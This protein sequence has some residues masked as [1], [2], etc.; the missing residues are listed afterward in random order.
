MCVCGEVGGR[1]EGGEGVVRAFVYKTC[2]YGCSHL[3]IYFVF[4][5]VSIDICGYFYM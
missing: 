1:G 4:L 3:L 5:Y 2:Y